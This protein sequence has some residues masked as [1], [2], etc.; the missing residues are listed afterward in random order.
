VVVDVPAGL[1]LRINTINMVLLLVVVLAGGALSDV[2]G[3]RPVLL[4]SA[5]AVL[6]CA[7]PLFSLLHHPD[8]W[9]ML[10]GQA[11]LALL[12]G[13]WLGTVPAAMAEA[14]PARVRC[15]ALSV[16]YNLTLGIVGGTT[17]LVATWLIS[18][19]H[20]DL[21]PA[22]LLM[23]AAAVSVVVVLGL[24]ETYHEPLR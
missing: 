15:T 5:L 18:R 16:G 2:V 9:A 6:L 24:R 20:D 23:A 7:W 3:R 10:M 11:A 4:G 21:S 8:F 13:P 12:L 14:Y 1:A 22:F 19:T 17:P